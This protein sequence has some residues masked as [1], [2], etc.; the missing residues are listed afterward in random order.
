MMMVFRRSVVASFF[1]FVKLLCTAE[2]VIG[3]PASTYNYLLQFVFL[4]I[5]FYRF[6]K[7]AR[8]LDVLVLLGKK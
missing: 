4:F 5:V 7:K 2:R 8:L 6:I 3:L 1:V